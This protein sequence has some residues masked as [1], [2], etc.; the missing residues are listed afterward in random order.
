[1]FRNSVGFEGNA[2]VAVNMPAISAGACVEFEMRCH[3]LK[4]TGDVVRRR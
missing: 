4:R 3:V 2:V 1:M